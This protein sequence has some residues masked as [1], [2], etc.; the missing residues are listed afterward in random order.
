MNT[1]T[2]EKF[3]C[4][5]PTLNLAAGA[6]MPVCF[7]FFSPKLL[8][9]FGHFEGTQVIG[10]NDYCTNSSKPKSCKGKYISLLFI[11]IKGDKKLLAKP[12]ENA[13]HWKTLDSVNG[14]SSCLFHLS[15]SLS[16]F[17][18]HFGIYLKAAAYSTNDGKNQ[19]TT[20]EDPQPNFCHLQVVKRYINEGNMKV[21]IFA[22]WSAIKA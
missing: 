13:Q 2:N 4:Y 1:K 17:D 5:W 14:Y 6:S 10:A 7:T 18:I 8:I 19:E 16:W 20:R 22:I 9:F 11:N 3:I 15:K 12:L 21:F